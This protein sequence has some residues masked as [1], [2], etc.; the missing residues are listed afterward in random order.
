[1][2]PGQ[3]GRGGP[4]GGR[5]RHRLRPLEDQG[6]PVRDEGLGRLLAPRLPRRRRAGRRPPHRRDH[7]PPRGAQAPL[8][9]APLRLLQGGPTGFDTGN[10]VIACVAAIVCKPITMD[11]SCLLTKATQRHGIMIV[12]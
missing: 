5:H 8:R 3:G 10:A 11:A 2:F 6:T 12:L 1:M 9:R 4:V 7:V